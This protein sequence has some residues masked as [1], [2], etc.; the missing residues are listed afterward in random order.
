MGDDSLTKTENQTLEQSEGSTI[1]MNPDTSLQAL[2]KRWKG[3]LRITLF[4][5]GL[6]SAGSYLGIFRVLEW[7][8]LDQFL[9]LRPQEPVD[10]RIAIV[11]ID[12]EDIDYVV[13]WPMADKVMAQLIRNIKAQNPNAIGLDIY[14]DLPVEP[15]HDER[16]EVFKTTPN[17]IG[18]TKIAGDTIDPPP[19]LADKGQVAANDMFLDN[20]SKIRR[21]LV[22]G[23]AESGL[24]QGFGVK[25]ALDYLADQGI[26]L[27]AINADK[28]IFGLGQAKFIP[29]SKNDG[30]YKESDLGWYQILV[31]YRGGLDRFPHISMTDV[32]E[33]RIPEN[34]FRDRIVL[35][36]SK[37]PSLNDNYLTPYNSNLAVP[38]DLMPGVVIH[39]NVTSQI[40]SAAI[41]GRPMLRATPKPIHWLIIV[42][43]SGYSATLGS[44]YIHRRWMTLLGL[45]VA[46]GIIVVSSYFAFLSGWLVPVFTPLLAVVVAATLS[47]GQVLWQNLMISYQKLE[48]YARNLED[49][50]KERT[51]ELAQANQEISQ[52]NEK[53]KAENLR[54]SAELDVARQ[55]QYMILP[56]SDELEAIEGLDIAGFM[57]PADEV[58]GDYYDILFT[59]NVVTVGIGDVTGHGL[60]SGILM[61]MT[62]TVV[63]T[64]DEIRERDPVKFLD[65]L[66][67]TLYKNVQRMNSDRNLTLAILNY[68]DGKVS[69]SGQH[70]E[71][72]V[73]RAG[74][75]IERIDT[76]D[77]GFPIALDD[78]IADFIDRALI[79]LQPGDSIV[80]YTDGIPEAENME[81]E[82]YGLERLCDVIRQNW[83]KSAA[84][85]KDAIIDN[86]RHF[87]GK[88]KVFDDITLVVLKQEA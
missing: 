34:L 52:L 53:L 72:I 79:E 62:Q 47:V 20:D 58:G 74:G 17:L 16:V 88:Q 66:N 18:I 28:Q 41:S 83:D 54:M 87:I 56:K 78:D 15:G 19:T 29:L 38:T 43:W 21:S 4:V 26:E 80:L 45:L 6:I 49:K 10:E 86:L 40:L 31:N 69:I 7:L 27:E 55:L 71:S 84:A 77:L 1:K 32:L 36:G 65:V 24:L 13:Q 73:V 9:L 44:F 57:E 14:R 8:I 51:A 39:A 37:A 3:V 81:N 85:M 25:L 46:V 60:E 48:D 50:V 76:M 23:E 35:I 11:T 5:A 30:F 42:V 75:I 64:L 68:T 67:R 22:L 33:N 12:E 70:E 59:D 63:R 2:L 61:M 82:Q